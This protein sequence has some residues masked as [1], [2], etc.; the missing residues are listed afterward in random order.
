MGDL[1]HTSTATAPATCTSAF[2]RVFAQ[3]LVVM[4]ALLDLTIAN[5]VD[6]FRQESIRRERGLGPP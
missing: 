1:R 2:R 5:F 4:R 6:R 3:A